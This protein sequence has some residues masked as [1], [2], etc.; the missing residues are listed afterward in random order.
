[1]KE[2]KYKLIGLQIEGIR[3]IKAAQLKFKP[4]GLTEIIGKNNQGKSSIIDAIE[5]LF[6]G[7]KQ[8]TDDIITHG[9]DKAVIIGDLDEFII[10][11]VMTGKTNRLEVIT[12]EGFKPQKPQDFLNTLINKLTFRPQVFLSKKP[13]EKLRSVMEILK[14]DFTKENIEIADKEAERLIVGRDL[15]YLGERQEPPE[16]LPVDTADLLKQKQEI[17]RFN[18]EE[19]EKQYDI[20]FFQSMLKDTDYRIESNTTPVRMAGLLKVQRCLQDVILALPAPIYKST[21]AIDQQISNASQTN[22]QAQNFKDYQAWKVNKADKQA[23]YEKLTNEIK[24]LKES[25]IQKLAETKMPV[26]GLKIKEVTENNY[27]LFYNDIYCENWSTSIGWKISLAICAAMQPDLKAIFLDNGE[28]LDS[29]TR[30]SLDEWAVKNDVQV[31]LT[32]VEKIPDTLVEGKFFIEEGRIFNSKGDCLPEESGPEAEPE[33][34]KPAPDKKDKPKY[35][36]QS[37]F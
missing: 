11:R 25:K 29:D 5:I 22:Q 26:K 31:I 24:S 34:D 13:E 23:K 28:A 2:K 32:V 4:S 3:L 10:K 9:A 16:V 18:E 21:D 36:T 37:L 20:T 17:Q 12:K 6:E 15:K 35:N 19:K 7:F 30:L 1:M 14:I 8:S 27:G 33:P